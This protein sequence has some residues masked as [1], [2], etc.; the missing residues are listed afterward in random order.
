M[1]RQ[2]NIL[3]VIIVFIVFLQISCF[4]KADQIEID[5]KIDKEGTRY[6]YTNLFTHHWN[7]NPEHNNDQELIGLEYYFHNDEFGGIAYFKNSFHQ[8]CYSIYLGKYFRIYD[9]NAYIIQESN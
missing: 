3:I 4:I 5:I 9:G 7:Y 2:K 6:I 1:K 8:P